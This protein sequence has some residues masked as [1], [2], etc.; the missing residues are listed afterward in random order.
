MSLAK[1]VGVVSVLIAFSAAADTY[2]ALK[3]ALPSSVCFERYESDGLSKRLR[4]RVVIT[5]EGYNYPAYQAWIDGGQAL[6]F[7]VRPGELIAEVRSHRPYERDST[8]PDE[9]RSPEYRVH[10]NAGERQILQVVPQPEPDGY[11]C[12]WI[13]KFDTPKPS[14]IP[15]EG[16]SQAA[17][18]LGR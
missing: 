10:L 12:D 17:P 4:S 13:I 3:G 16:D 9:C 7:F 14:N 8:D 5:Y 1:Y 6:C 11:E 18:Q 2:S 15:L